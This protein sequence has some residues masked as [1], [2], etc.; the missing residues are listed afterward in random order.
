VNNQVTL[1]VAT[2]NTVYFLTMA[3]GN[4][5]VLLSRQFLL[6]LVVRE[7][8]TNF[9]LVLT[10]QDSGPIGPGPA[11]PSGGFGPFGPAGPALPTGGFG[12]FG[13]GPALPSG[14]FGPFGTA[15]PALPTGGFGPFGPSGPALPSGGFGPFG[16]GPAKPPSSIF[17]SATATA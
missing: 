2:Y 3:R 6:N 12:P 11:L 15:G 9:D 1:R 16:P 13:P 14:G 17:A 5:P 8:L 4:F 7:G 10:R